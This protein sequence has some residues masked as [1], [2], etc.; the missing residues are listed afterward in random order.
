MKSVYKI[1]FELDNRNLNLSSYKLNVKSAYKY[2]R[3][4]RIP[5]ARSIQ[6]LKSVRANNTLA[7]N[8]RGSIQNLRNDIK[9]TLEGQIWYAEVSRTVH[10]RTFTASYPLSVVKVDG[11]EVSPQT[12]RAQAIEIIKYDLQQYRKQLKHR[13][14]PIFRRKPGGLFKEFQIKALHSHKMPQDNAQYV[15]IEVE[16]VM[17][18]NVDTSPLLPFAKYVNITTDGSVEHGRNETG[19]EF[20]ICM[21]RDQIREMLP[22]IMQALKTMGGTVNKS[23][24]LHVHMDQRH[25]SIEAAGSVFQRLV[26]SLG[27]LYTVVPSSRR[28]NTF[29]KR[30]RYADF[31][32]A[33]HG[34]RYKAVNATAYGKHRT[35]EVR[36]FGGTLEESKIINWIEVLYA[37]AEGETVLRC[38]KTFDTALKYWKLS[39]ENMAWLK[40]RQKQFSTINAT[41]PISES[42]TEENNHI[43]DEYAEEDDEPYCENC[44]T[45]GDHWTSDCEA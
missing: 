23:C 1:A 2:I 7:N 43:M 36:L 8:M 9:N 25:N 31:E 11:Q 19:S 44:D 10:G 42:E 14:D 40:E 27:L 13:E 20:R 15:G 32:K 33:R 35:I 28:K 22:P 34:E 18:Q 30:N 17:P 39:D 26:R 6:A 45:G 5:F 4:V 41:L 12:Y 38:P 3:S 16:C 21:R 24:G 37:I 29:C